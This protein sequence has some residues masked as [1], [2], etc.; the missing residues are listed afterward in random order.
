MTDL[1][2]RVE[3]LEEEVGIAPEYELWVELPSDHG[4]VPFTETII[5]PATPENNEKHNF[6]GTGF[7]VYTDHTEEAFGSWWN[8][9]EHSPAHDGTDDYE[10]G[11]WYGTGQSVS[12]VDR[13]EVFGE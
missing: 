9:A 4:Y 8:P 3:R 1:E 7:V 5:S 12:F 2:E 13:S 10:A 6:C 11:Y